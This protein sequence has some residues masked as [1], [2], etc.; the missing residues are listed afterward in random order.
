MGVARLAQVVAC[1]IEALWLGWRGGAPGAAG[2]E[3]LMAKGSGSSQDPRQTS[4]AP[5]RPP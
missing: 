1:P 3:G 4:A 5:S 2:E